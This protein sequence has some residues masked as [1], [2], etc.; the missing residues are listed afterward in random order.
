MFAIMFL[1]SCLIKE[2][3][4]YKTFDCPEASLNSAG[5]INFKFKQLS[6][7]K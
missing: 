3:W 2:F 5:I 7:S 4:N 6:I 1:R